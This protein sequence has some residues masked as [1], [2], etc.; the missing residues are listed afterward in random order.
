M[1]DILLILERMVTTGILTKEQVRKA[2]EQ[3]KVTGVGL[4]KILIK[5]GFV[6]EEDLI[7]A[8]AEEKGIPYM[9][10]KDYLIDID[11]LNL[12]PEKLAKEKNIIPLFKIGNTLTIAMSEPQDL[13]TIDQIRLRSGLDVEAV[14][15]TPTAIANAIDQ[16]YGASGTMEEVLGSIEDQGLIKTSEDMGVKAL[17]ELAQEAPVVKFVNMLIMEAVKDRASDIHLEPEENFL[18]IRFR[19]DGVLQ[20]IS[21]PPKHIQ[22]AIISRIK[23]LSKMDIA[24]KRKPQDGQLQMRVEN[25]N[26]DVRASTFPT[27]YGENVVLRILDKANVILELSQLG[28]AADMLRYFKEL[29]ERPNGIILVTGPT[30]SGKTTTLYA[31]IQAINSENRNIITLE[32]PVE[33]HLPMIRQSQINPKA[34]VTF[35]NGLRSI[36]RQDPD[37]IMVGEI[38]DLETADIAVQ[39]ALTGHLVFSTLHTNDAAGTVTR[40]L[41]MGVEPFLVSS[42]VIGILAQRLVRVVCNKCKEEYT[43]TE[44]FYGVDKFYRGKGCRGCKNS[45]FHGRVGIYELL[46]M[47]DKIKKLIVSKAS[48]EDIKKAAQEAG[49]RTLREDGVLKVKNGLTTIEEVLRVTAEQ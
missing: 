45:G 9:D 7:M 23:V 21:S 4:D 41:D 19:I 47:N 33:Y 42:S 26:I 31:A 27:I 48:S 30:G 36:L 8:V 17:E 16:F 38:R 20:E 12:V 10:L 49:M 40:L 3:S 44:K 18:R 22:A 24:E 14:L 43:P 13:M 37:V 1:K 46:L 11:T 32:D 5:D 28:F 29:I 15:S 25:R 35:A 39:A 2:Q 6:S 34:G